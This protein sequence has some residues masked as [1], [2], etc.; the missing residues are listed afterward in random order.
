VA[1]HP[2]ARGD[3]VKVN[4]VDDLLVGLDHAVGH[5]DAEV[6]LRPEHGDPKPPLEH[7]LVLRRP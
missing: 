1:R 7:D 4:L 6:F 2:F 5:I 3:R